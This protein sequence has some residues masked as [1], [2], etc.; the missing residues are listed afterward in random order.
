MR[1]PL[2]GNNTQISLIPLCFYI[3]G[4]QL[5]GDCQVTPMTMFNEILAI[6]SNPMTYIGNSIYHFSLPDND[7]PI[8]SL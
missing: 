4:Q 1:Y 5:L 3:Q 6:I 2:G 8:T 7:R